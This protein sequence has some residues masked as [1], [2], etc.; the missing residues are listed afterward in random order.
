MKTRNGFVSNSSSSSFVVAFPRLPETPRDVMDM[1]FPESADQDIIKCFDHKEICIN[2]AERVWLDVKQQVN[3]TPEEDAEHWSR[4]CD[5]SPKPKSLFDKLVHAFKDRYY[6][7]SGSTLDFDRLINHGELVEIPRGLSDPDSY[8]GVHPESL[9]EV[10]K[11][12]DELEE[13]SRKRMNN[14]RELRDRLG[15]VDPPYQRNMS[16]DDMERRRE[17]WA[18]NNAKLKSNEEWIK[19]EEE[20]QENYE[21]L[22]KKRSKAVELVAREDAAAFLKD[23]G[24]KFI[25]FTHYADDTEPLMEH[26]EIFRNLPYVIISHH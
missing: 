1:M 11:I 21:R 8:F 20:H 2:I 26:G 23:N 9:R 13:L 10:C 17:Q 5:E 4:Y 7:L 6:Y 15:L 14:E 25:L 16:D 24:D 22:N 19:M 3:R 12:E 18:L